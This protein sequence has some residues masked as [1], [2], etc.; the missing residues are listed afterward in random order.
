[1]KEKNNNLEDNVGFIL[2]QDIKNPPIEGDDESVL[3][4]ARERGFDTCPICMMLILEKAVITAEC[5]HKFCEPCLTK[6][7]EYERIPNC[8]CGDPT[9]R[10]S[11]IPCPTCKD[12]YTKFF[13]CKML[14]R[15]GKYF[16]CPSDECESK[17]MD[18]KE[19]EKHIR[20]LCPSRKI[21]CK[22]G[23]RVPALKYND[24]LNTHTNK[25]HVC[26]NIIW[27]G[28]TEHKCPLRK[29]CC[30]LCNAKYI[31]QDKVSHSSKCEMR[32]VSCS[33]CG[34]SGSYR[35]II[36][37]EDSCSFEKCENCNITFRSDKLVEHSADCRE[38]I[39]ECQ[40][41]GCSKKGNLM[42][43][44]YHSRIDHIQHFYVDVGLYGP[45][46]DRLF[47]IHDTMNNECMAELIDFRI[48]SNDQ[49]MGKFSYIKWL[50]KWD[51]WIDM[52]SSRISNLSPEKVQHIIE[53][54]SEY[55]KI[56]C[57]NFRDPNLKTNIIN[58]KYSYNDVQSLIKIDAIFHE[59][60]HNK[61][62]FDNFS[63]FKQHMLKYI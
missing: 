41:K 21:L 58:R 36:I 16:S 55:P 47:I 24:H 13:P 44:F 28:E 38:E 26:S 7:E 34:M 46:M 4:L 1:M 53:V 17:N 25:C 29:V 62:T 30:P 60:L 37:H 33:E 20:F 14:F 11:E 19:F 12:K 52:S 49:S 63:E 22:C 2:D 59:T 54:P 35:E 6:Y 5:G 3:A 50:N 45:E 8:K 56:F 61:P 10:K 31:A 39:Y 48:N 51:E 43:L 15:D 32:I 40:S 42:E 18:L 57:K 9:H 27:G 23:T